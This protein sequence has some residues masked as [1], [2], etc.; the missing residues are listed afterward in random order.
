MTEKKYSS[1]S[2]TDNYKPF[3]SEKETLS[4]TAAVKKLYR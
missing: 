2:A 4:N 3:L 1:T